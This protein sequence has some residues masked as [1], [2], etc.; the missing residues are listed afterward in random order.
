MIEE[1]KSTK[2]KRKPNKIEAF[3]SL[4]FLIIVVLIGNFF[5]GI[6]IGA[7]LALSIGYVSIIAWRCGYSW[8]DIKD[9]MSEKVTSILDIF[10]ILLGVGF[11]VAAWMFSGTI[12]TLITYMV[13]VINPDYVIVLTFILCAIL[14]MIIG[15]GWGTAGTLGVVM[16]GLGLTLGV[17]M[18]ALA[19]AVGCGSHVGQILSPMA[20]MVNLTAVLGKK[21]PMDMAKRS[22]YFVIPT[23]IISIIVCLIVGFT[24]HASNTSLDEIDV[25]VSSMKEVFHISIFSL[26]PFVFL[27]I[28]AVMKKPILPVLFSSGLI[29]LVV[30]VFVNGFS[31]AD[32]LMVVHE[33]FSLS[34]LGIDSSTVNPIVVTLVERGGMLSFASVF[35]TLFLALGYAG[36]M[37]KIG[38]LDVIVTTLFGKIKNTVGLAVS[39]CLVGIITAASTSNSYLTLLLPVELLGEKYEQ[40]GWDISNA[41]AVSG[42]VGT[43]IMMVIP[44]T[45][46]GLYIS[47][48]TGVPILK[49]APYA[50]LSYGCCIIAVITSF[51]KF[52]WEKKR[53]EI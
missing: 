12:P 4:L 14:S 13:K 25:I 34:T 3:S 51:I 52:G 26:L 5:G 46:T 40:N 7:P 1:E 30:G 2:V 47:E 37:V 49:F 45:T 10:F 44:W 24:S 42:S 41:A 15:T 32:G 9:A 16:I 17:N 18:P 27:L 31:L 6:G 53:T 50:I 43:I 23:V 33:G 11:L 39:T 28:L 38:S 8:D 21:Q 36:I 20:D 48:V 22:A 29:A 19:A 35:V